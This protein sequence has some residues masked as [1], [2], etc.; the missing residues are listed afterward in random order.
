MTGVWVKEKKVASLGVAIRSWIAFHGLSINIYQDD[1][2]NFRLIRP[3][4][5]DIEMT[6][7]ESLLGRHIETDVVKD[8]IVGNFRTVFGF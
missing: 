1:L 5:M 3:C 2:D 7:L 4:G 6:S 8:K